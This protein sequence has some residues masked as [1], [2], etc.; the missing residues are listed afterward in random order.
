[1]TPIHDDAEHNTEGRKA[2]PSVSG[3]KSSFGDTLNK[4][5]TFNRRRTTTTTLLPHSA[6]TTNIYPKSRLPT[7]SGVPR[8]T[9]F[10]SSLSNF[11]SKTAANHL[12][13]GDENEPPPPPPPSLSKCQRKLS[14]RLAH[15]PFFAQQQQQQRPT[16]TGVSAAPVTPQKKRDSSIRIE[17]RGLMQPMPPPLPRS[18]TMGDLLSAQKASSNNSL[19]LTPNSSRPASRMKDRGDSLARMGS[20][21]SIRVVKLQKTPGSFPRRKD[22]L[23]PPPEPTP[24]ARRQPS[25]DFQAGAVQDVV[26]SGSGDEEEGEGVLRVESP[27]HASSNESIGKMRKSNSVFR[28]DF[29]KT[30]K[31]IFTPVPAFVFLL[32]QRSGSKGKEMSGQADWGIA[33]VSKSERRPRIAPRI[34][35]TSTA[36]PRLQE[37]EA[38]DKET[39]PEEAA[40]ETQGRDPDSQP[41]TDGT[42]EET[43]DPRLASPPNIHPPSLPLTDK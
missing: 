28:E 34:S 22:S 1:M 35:H 21:P 42:A 2:R 15:A 18:S 26:P 17:Q 25:G 38:N 20:P 33:D 3:R 40:R 9:S 10:L 19:Q 4:F 7:P 41:K 31:R 30:S 39:I 27:R 23:M 37:I 32:H 11:A 43:G 12:V 8:S 24:D 16:N 13:Y 36:P 14:S 5:T 29:E 6:S